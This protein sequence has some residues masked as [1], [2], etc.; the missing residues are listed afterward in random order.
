[1]IK[2]ILSLLATMAITAMATPLVF[3]NS[4]EYKYFV[5][6]A[7]GSGPDQVAR[8]IS[9]LVKDQSGIN[10]IIVNATGGNGLMAAMDFK[11]EP[12]DP[13]LFLS[14]LILAGAYR[15]E[16]RLSNLSPFECLT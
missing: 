11:K 15:L 7:V 4:V 14:C 9:Q 12:I 6:A 10:L 5:Q 13:W 16:G 3:A 8:K 1:M 2:K